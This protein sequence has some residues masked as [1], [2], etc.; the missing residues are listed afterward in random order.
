MDLYGDTLLPKARESLKATE[1]AFRA[2]R[3]SFTDLVDAE[4]VLL[5]FQLSQERALA[6]YAQRLAE[7]EMLVGSAIPRTA[8]VSPEPVNPENEH[9]QPK[10]EA[11]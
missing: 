8:P 11:P 1:A 10:G 9:K 2:G 6:S 7:L 4:R 5:E 3:A